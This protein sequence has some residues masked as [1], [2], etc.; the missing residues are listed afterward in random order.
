MKTWHI[1]LVL[2]VVVGVLAGCGG[3]QAS[4]VDEGGSETVRLSAHGEAYR[5]ARRVSGSPIRR[6]LMRY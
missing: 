1:G 3:E 5:P 4:P 6:C 2:A